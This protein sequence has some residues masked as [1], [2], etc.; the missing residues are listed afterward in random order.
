MSA[1]LSAQFS[2]IERVREYATELPEEAAIYCCPPKE[3]SADHGSGADVCVPS[4]VDRISDAEEADFVDRLNRDGA[5]VAFEAVCLRYRPRL[6]LVLR[7]VSFTAEAGQRVGLVGRT[8]SGKSTTMLAI[9]RLVELASGTIRLGGTDVGRVPL[10]TLRSAITIIPQ[11]PVLFVGTVRSNLDPFD[12]ETDEAL[13][14]AL[15]EVGLGDRLGADGLM[16]PVTA[17]GANFSVGQRQLLCLARA[18]LRH[19]PVLLLDEATASVDSDTDAL[20]QRTIRGAFRGATV[21][22]IAHRLATV[23]DCDQIVVLKDGGVL[24][25]GPPADLVAADTGAF[26]GM[27][28]AQEQAD[29]GAA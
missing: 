28:A 11:D 20:I 29:G 6:P 27:V 1:Q 2:A 21:L 3:D 16:A 18:L 23:M 15:G 26:A 22:I 7:D 9:F 10:A 24:E 8:G 4:V 25:V 19:S 13:E 17:K 14:T 5:V 12:Q